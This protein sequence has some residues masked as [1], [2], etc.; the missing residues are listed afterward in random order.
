MPSGELEPL[1]AP[2]PP[3][4]PSFMGPWTPELDRLDPTLDHDPLF[5][6]PVSG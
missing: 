1:P 6:G 4:G 5:D 2:P 3:I